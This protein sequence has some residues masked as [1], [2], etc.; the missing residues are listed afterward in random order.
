MGKYAYIVDYQSGTAAENSVNMY[1][2]VFSTRKKA[3]D[4][5]NEMIEMHIGDGYRIKEDSPKA[6]PFD[7]LLRIVILTRKGRNYGTLK[8]RLIKLPIR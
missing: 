2:G 7:F 5:I 4:Y 8:Y 3:N 1:E 6:L